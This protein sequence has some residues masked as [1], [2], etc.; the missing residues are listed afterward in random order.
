MPK[1]HASYQKAIRQNRV[2]LNTVERMIS[3]IL[4]YPLIDTI[5]ETLERTVFRILPMQI[6]F[7]AVTI[8]GLLA[9]AVAYFYGYQTMS[10]T[11]LSYVFVL[12]FIVG[13]V[14]EYVRSIIQQPK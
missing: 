10:L 1:K 3:T 12:G 11:S 6:G 4:H 14:F 8:F 5:L 13:V 9:V 7:I 2:H